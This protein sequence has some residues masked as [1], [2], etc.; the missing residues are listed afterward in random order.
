[1]DQP[2]DDQEPDGSSAMGGADFERELE[3][4]EV[5]DSMSHGNVS[6]PPVR[7]PR[8]PR[9]SVHDEEGGYPHSS[10]S[11]KVPSIQTFNQQQPPI[12]QQRGSPTGPVHSHSHSRSSYD[13]RSPSEK[14]RGEKERDRERYG[15]D[16]P[17][18]P[19]G[20]RGLMNPYNNSPDGNR[21]EYS[22]N[23]RQGKEPLSPKDDYHDRDR[24]R[25]DYRSRMPPSP[26]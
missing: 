22:P 20:M 10:S 17:K 24:E 13:S 23:S 3:G 5:N 7:S 15:P 4:N 21:S 9:G 25:E 16:S 2:P 19:S 1:M 11:S 12:S 18:M 8:G 6:P 26:Q 14:D